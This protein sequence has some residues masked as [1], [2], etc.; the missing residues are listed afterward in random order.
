MSAAT[1]SI[2]IH[3]CVVRVAA[4]AY[5]ASRINYRL[6]IIAWLID[7]A[8]ICATGADGG[9]DVLDEQQQR[10]ILCILKGLQHLAY[11]KNI[12]TSGIQ[13]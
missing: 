4:P 13:Q 9:L 2:A 8:P 10:G 5:E 11:V 3:S 12:I 1:L 7:L 6:S